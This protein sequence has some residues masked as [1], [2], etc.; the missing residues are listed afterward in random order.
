MM[1]ALSLGEVLLEILLWDPA[2]SSSVSANPYHTSV[3]LRYAL[4]YNPTLELLLVL[5]L[6]VS[7][8]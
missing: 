6:A 4:S 1:A 2:A 3:E 8:R 5:F 7:N